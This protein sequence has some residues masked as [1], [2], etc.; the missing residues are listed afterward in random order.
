MI[1]THAEGATRALG[2]PLVLLGRTIIH[3][4]EDQ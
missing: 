3:A 1:T 2:L 4:A